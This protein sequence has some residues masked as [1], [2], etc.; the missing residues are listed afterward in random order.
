MLFSLFKESVNGFDLWSNSTLDC[1][2]VNLEAVAL[3]SDKSFLSDKFYGKFVFKLAFFGDY[4]FP[5]LENFHPL[6]F[7]TDPLSEIL[8]WLVL[9]ELFL[10]EVNG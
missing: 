9:C 10:I 5:F 1:N 2:E 3:L 6:F 7:A 4:I 8:T